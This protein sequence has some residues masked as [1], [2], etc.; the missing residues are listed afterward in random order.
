MSSDRFKEDLSAV[1]GALDTLLRDAQTHDARPHDRGPVAQGMSPSDA[2]SARVGS[3]L[4]ALEKLDARVKGLSDRQPE[5]HNRGPSSQLKHE[6]G[7]AASRSVRDES[8]DTPAL[9]DALAQIAQR[10]AELDRDSHP[11]EPEPR[12]AEKSSYQP[13][14]SQSR[15]PSSDNPAFWGNLDTH[16]TYA[17]PPKTTPK[18]DVHSQHGSAQPVAP[19][20]GAMSP[21]DVEKHFESL[22]ARIDGFRVPQEQAIAELKRDIGALRH[23]VADTQKGGQVSAP[24]DIGRLSEALQEL[25]Q[26]QIGKGQIDAVRGEIQSLRDIIQE[27][28][29]AGMVQS[30][31][32]GY[33]H[34]VQRL[35]EL[36]RST[37][38]PSVLDDLTIRLDEIEKSFST[39]PSLEHMGALDNRI[40]NLAR[41]FEEIPERIN[42]A[43]FSRLQSDIAGVRVSVEALTAGDL[44]E[45][46]DLKMQAMTNRLDSLQESTVDHRGLEERME[47]I[48]HSLP[49]PATFA[50]IEKRMHDICGMLA[51]DGS[52]TKLGQMAG[53]LAEVLSRL[54]RIEK[55]AAKA[56][57]DA[58]LELIE[59]RI[60]EVGSK[61]DGLGNSLS[62]EQERGTHAIEQAVARLDSNVGPGSSAGN[63]LKDLE[64]RI[65]LLTTRLAEGNGQEISRGISELRNELSTMRAE[66]MAPLSATAEL[67]NQIQ[68]M[69]Q[70]LSSPDRVSG[71][72]QILGE[73]ENK[74]AG[75]TEQI[76][77][78]EKRIEGIAEI[79]RAI[80]GIGARLE[81]NERTAIEA[82]QA[83]VREAI[84]D[85]R[86]SGAVDPIVLGLQDDLSRLMQAAESDKY[87]TASSLENVQQTMSSIMTRLG[88][89]ENSSAAAPRETDFAGPFPLDLSQVE[90]GTFTRSKPSP[91]ASEPEVLAT[92]DLIDTVDDRPLE[93][94]TGRLARTMESS[95][96]SPGSRDPK[97]DFIAAARRAAQAASAEVAVQ[98]EESRKKE[99][100][101]REKSGLN[102]LRSKLNRDESTA[103]TGKTKKKKAAKRRDP[104]RQ[105][106]KLDP[107]AEKRWKRPDDGSGETVTEKPAQPDDELVLK[108]SDVVTPA[109]QNKGVRNLASSSTSSALTKAGAF[110]NK[111]RKPLILAAAA[112]VLAIGA[113]QIYKFVGPTADTGFEV[114]KQE[115]V[116]SVDETASI[117]PTNEA[118]TPDASVR[119]VEA[120]PTQSPQSSTVP[121][122]ADPSNLNPPAADSEVDSKLAFAAPALPP[123]Q[124]APSGNAQS[125]NGFVPGNARGD[126][127][128]SL[129]TFSGD[130]GIAVPGTTIVPNNGDGS[131]GNALIQ[132]IGSLA[133]RTAAVGG[134]PAAQF[135]VAVRLTEGKGIR[136]NLEQ[137]AQWYER[138]A[139]QDLAPAQYRLASLYEKGRGVK[140]D[141]GLAQAWYLKSARQGNAKAMHNLAV[142]YAEGAAGEPKFDDAA[143]WFQ[144]AA[145]HGV[146]DSQYNLGIL[147]ARGLSVER[148]LEESYKWFALAAKQGD[149]DAGSKRD[150]IANAMTADMLTRAQ[151]AVDS[152]KDVVL[153]EAVNSVPVDPA[154]VDKEERS[155]SVERVEDND[156]GGGPLVQKAQALL[157]ELGYDPGPADGVPGPKT[158]SAIREFQE[159]I[160]M[161][162]N[163]QINADLVRELSSRSI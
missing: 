44:V 46:I 17:E 85:N 92:A 129:G 116:I 88:Q 12:Y 132:E 18:P 124:F 67:E 155:A 160:G 109:G 144:K 71:D 37:N 8:S 40:A 30:L 106:P 68:H 146:R 22:A 61:L 105:D 86:T 147:Y 24:E 162:S 133:L 161:P 96:E 157:T 97:A 60:A 19:V 41:R 163:G 142:L 35:D 76:A 25:H 5:A 152:W 150:E 29:Q 148:N 125:A 52:D 110:A 79:E 145:S 134:D 58:A 139:N 54:E 1:A 64:A 141:L 140:K 90:D 113:L 10:R 103:S 128:N 89:L 4:K 126:V 51:S 153:D 159:T 14:R 111:N 6:P 98:E 34:I 99:Q 149:R 122:T 63:D 65:E 66:V 28:S 32:R 100:E 38:N 115:N 102:W 91:S 83:T 136:P 117:A 70:V 59:R 26:S 137:A 151:L 13:D 123:G 43:D 11:Q 107:V 39:L 114:A 84:S 118:I 87:D 50:E 121:T 47:Q 69:A 45:A 80:D 53:Q 49:N 27:N 93:P 154:W 9:R 138:A 23:E 143:N 73:V 127:D 15:Q 33:S 20:V 104:K 156:T 3:V 112:I 119:S 56:N 75:L 77:E 130:T 94:G 72:S 82:A 81:N 36:S 74:I 62:D 2:G 48:Q 101:R 42:P 21:Q 16:S 120:I 31:E 7:V 108:E 135:E 78:T 57:Q 95:K 158:R 131:D 55:N